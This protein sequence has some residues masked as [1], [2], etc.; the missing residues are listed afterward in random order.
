M[1][2]VL[3]K[4]LEFFRRNFGQPSHC[5]GRAHAD[6]VIQTFTRIYNDVF[7]ETNGSVV[8]HVQS[9]V[10]TRFGIKD[11]PAGWCFMPVS[12]GGLGII[13]PIVDL[14]TVRE[15]V[16]EEP[17]GAFAK[18]MKE[19][20]VAYLAA[21]ARWLGGAEWLGSAGVSTDETFMPF[22]EYIL[23]RE[24]AMMTW[25]AVWEHLQRVAD[26][27]SLHIVA[28]DPKW[29]DRSDAERWVTA[30][31][32]EEIKARFGDLKIVEP[33]LIPVGMLS[34]FRSAKIAWDS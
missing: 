14:L 22:S 23:G 15:N 32:E 1:L 17:S 9:V 11:V 27:R 6:E 10:Q 28:G 30:V 21:E 31:Y 7:S 4:Y 12:E 26:S 25:G 2:I 34:A 33:T 24:T 5:F 8:K 20:Q 3:H 18:R 16:D 13:N 29:R 19:D